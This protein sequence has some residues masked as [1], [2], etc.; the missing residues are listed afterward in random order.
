MTS[1]SVAWH[2]SPAAR[3]T[4][5]NCSASPLT[6]SSKTRPPGPFRPAIGPC[7]RNRALVEDDDVVA[8]VLDVGQQVRRQ[9]EVESLVVGDVANELEH[10]VAPLRVHAV[11]RLVEKQQI[12]IV[13]ERLRQLDAL[14]H[15]GGIL[16]DRSGNGPR[17][18]RR[19]RALRARAAS[20]RRAAART[21]RRNRRRTTRRSSAGCARRSPACSR[22]ERESGAATCLTSSPSTCIW[23]GRA[24][25]ARAAP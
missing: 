8:R 1:S 9:D 23:P 15:A 14:L 2:S 6:R 7:G 19:S 24:P 25:G 5:T 22:C 16:V 18:G 12:R 20:H 3:R 13:H 17:R 21:A 11:G 4:P 10:L